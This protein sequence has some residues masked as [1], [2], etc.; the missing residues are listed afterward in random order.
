MRGGGID[1]EGMD[2]NYLAFTNNDFKYIIYDNYYAQKEKYSIGIKIIN[3]KTLDT[4]VIKG[5]PKTQKGTLIKFRDDELIAKDEM[6]Y[7]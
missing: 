3:L 1:N 4:L 2:L 5:K 7:D 6:L